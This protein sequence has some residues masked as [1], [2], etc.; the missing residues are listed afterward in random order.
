MKI[1]KCKRC[2]YSTNILRCFKSHLQ[3]K[4]RCKPKLSDIPIEILKEAVDALSP[5]SVTYPNN[6]DTI[7]HR[8]FLYMLREREFI[9][10]CELIYKV[11]KTTQEIHKR[12]CSYPKNSELLL[13]IKFSDCH[14]AETELLKLLRNNVNLKQRKDIG[15]EYFEGTDTEIM[16]TFFQMI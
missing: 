11:G 15:S 12:L 10:T 9:K 2:G 5:S 16:K 8:G 4:F 3:R 6:M 1:H 14:K 13:A 7:D